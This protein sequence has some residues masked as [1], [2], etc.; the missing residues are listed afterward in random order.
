M[1]N[2]TASYWKKLAALC[3]LVLGAFAI[4]AWADWSAPMSAPPTC[5][6]GNPGCDAPLNVG[7]SAQTKYGALSLGQT[8][9]TGQTATFN[10]GYT[11]ANH[12]YAAASIGMLMVNGTA[13]FGTA[14]PDTS[15]KVDIESGRLKVG[16]GLMIPTG[17]TNGYVLTSDNQG[18]ATWQANSGSSAGSGIHF[19]NNPGAGYANLGVPAN[20]SYSTYSA[21]SAG[22]P[23]GAASALLWVNWTGGYGQNCTGIVYSSVPGSSSSWDMPI[24]SLASPGNN[25]SVPEDGGQAWV[26][27]TNGNIYLKQTETGGCASDF[28]VWVVGYS[29]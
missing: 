25:T 27:I 4:S 1:N 19:M 2:T 15:S 11:D 21:A 17:A 18:N 9:T 26:P 14:N 22:I 3:G 20:G 16:A 13:G 12:T 10:N 28:T 7:T 29:Y 24:L 23:S 8:L 6:P 5:T